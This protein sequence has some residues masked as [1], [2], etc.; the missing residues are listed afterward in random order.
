MRRTVIVLSVLVL[1]VAACGDD[2]TATTAG[3]STAALTTAA[4]A[5]TAPATTAATT[6]PTTAAPATTSAP[7]VTGPAAFIASAADYVGEY[8]GRW[9]NATFG[10]SGAVYFNVLEANTEAGYV[11]IQVDADGNAFG[12]ADPELFVIE[13]SIDGDDLHVGFSEFLGASSFEIDEAGNF[14][15]TAEPP[16]L[17]ST[18]EIAGSITADGFGGTYNIPGLA[19]GSWSATPAG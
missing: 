2:D 16:I 9:D 7:A 5:T 17:G 10:S 8:V 4:T 6:P 18:I 13:I 19:E 11:L 12:A 14:T 1:A 3:Q 15:M